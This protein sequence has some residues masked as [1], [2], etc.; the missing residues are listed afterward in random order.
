MVHPLH[1]DQVMELREAWTQFWS[2]LPSTRGDGETE[3]LNTKEIESVESLP[4]NLALKTYLC[5][6]P[7]G[8]VFDL[9]EEN[10]EVVRFI[11][12]FWKESDHGPDFLE[13]HYL[14]T[15]ARYGQLLKEIM[16]NLCNDK[17]TLNWKIV[18]DQIQDGGELGY[19]RIVKDDFQKIYVEIF[20]VLSS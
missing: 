14:E 6:N 20:I 8:T 15:D 11:K 10:I 16:E 1:S 13:L 18:L 17:S 3:E 2:S 4:D 12:E 19:F 7:V 5:Q 9:E